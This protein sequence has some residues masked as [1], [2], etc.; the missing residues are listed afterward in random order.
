MQRTVRAASTADRE[1]ILDVC[2]AAFVT[3][4]AFRHFFHDAY[5]PHARTF[6]AFLLDL[7]LAGGLVWVEEVAG[8]IV[9]ASMWDPPGGT[10][11]SEA[12][13]EQ[14]WQE[15]A[16]TFPDDA[17]ARLDAYE[18]QVHVF[19][20]STDH[21]YLGVLASDPAARGRG[22]G[23]AVLRPGLVAADAE[24]LASFLETGTE[25][26]L[27]FYSRFGFEVSD[28]LELADRTRVWFLTRPPDA[29]LG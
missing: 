13:Q 25:A 7:R 1:P 14:M 23:A 9:S 8:R 15:A 18:E 29:G 11:L 22:H 16:A 3:E 26:N 12:Q 5:H 19:A 10:R 28:E 20:P 2:T 27:G 17:V 6:L 4:P 24:G 21:Y